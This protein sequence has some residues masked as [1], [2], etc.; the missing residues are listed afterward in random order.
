MGNNPINWSDPS[1]MGPLEFFSCLLSTGFLLICL[2]DEAERFR[3][4]KIKSQAIEDCKKDV[5]ENKC[6]PPSG[7]HDAFWKC[8]NDILENAG[9]LT[10]PAI[11]TGGEW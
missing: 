9:C 10:H 4:R 6:Y 2:E 5:L 8:I 7:N 3:C 11:G 1:G